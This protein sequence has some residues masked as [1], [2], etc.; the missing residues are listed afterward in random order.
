[1]NRAVAVA[2]SWYRELDR[3][4]D[5]VASDAELGELGAALEVELEF[6]LE[7]PTVPRSP[8][9]ELLALCRRS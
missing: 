2:S 7:E 1:M 9:R 4:A 3:A 8:S 5:R 6:E